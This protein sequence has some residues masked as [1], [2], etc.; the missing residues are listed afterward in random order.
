MGAG[1]L[2]PRPLICRGDD[3]RNNMH[4]YL[5]KML[6]LFPQQAGIIILLSEQK[7]LKRIY[8]FLLSLCAA[9]YV[10]QD[11]KPLTNISGLE[12]ASAKRRIGNDN[13]TRCEI[14]FSGMEPDHV[15]FAVG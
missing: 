12:C 4:F 7:A 8:F 2:Y 11:S 9:Q 5:V 1:P 6:P 15:S 13:N 3:G 10:K 14:M